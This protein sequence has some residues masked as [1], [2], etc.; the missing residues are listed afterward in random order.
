MFSKIVRQ[1]E[2]NTCF[3]PESYLHYVLCVV[4]KLDPTRISSSVYWMDVS[5]LHVTFLLLLTLLTAPNLADHVLPPAG[6]A[7]VARPKLIL[8]A[9]IL[10]QSIQ[11]LR[12]VMGWFARDAQRWQFR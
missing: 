4:L 3:P 6:S 10:S 9:Y 1:G 7:A 2:C 5:G 11:C 12:C 8:A